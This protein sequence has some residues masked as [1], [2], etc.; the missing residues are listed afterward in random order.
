M[1]LQAEQ[2]EIPA[3][4]GSMPGAL[5]RPAGEGP[6]PGV[7]VLMESFGLTAHIRGV[8]ARLAGAGYLALAPDLYYRERERVVPY[9]RPEHAVNKLMRTIAL[10]AARD[11]A[12][13][14]ERVT[15]DMRAALMALASDPGTAGKRTGVV[16]FCMGGRLAFLLACRAPERVGA[17]VSFYGGRIV[18]IVEEARALQAPALLLFAAEDES[19]P[20]DH[21][22]RIRAELLYRQKLH[23]IHVYPGAG[24]GFFCDERPGFAPEASADAWQRTLDWLGK[25]LR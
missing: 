2:V 3:P 4:G 23:E 9:D 18:P 19:T 6:H 11:E 12:A 24:Q 13:K 17:F 25:H 15:A 8:A 10:S 7:L 5:Y 16:G 20:Y 1:Q 21:V 14:D 22:D